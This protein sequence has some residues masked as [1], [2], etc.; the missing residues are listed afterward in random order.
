LKI[1]EV[2]ADLVLKMS[3]TG[4]PKT[5]GQRP[6]TPAP[7]STIIDRDITDKP[8]VLDAAENVRPK[9]HDERT[10]MPESEPAVIDIDISGESPVFTVTVACYGC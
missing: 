10:L 3:E 5:S 9:T 8:D 7:T 2:L 6:V 1:R 4:R